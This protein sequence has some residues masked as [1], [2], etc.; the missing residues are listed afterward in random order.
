[1]SCEVSRG[2]AP[3]AYAN[4]LVNIGAISD[5]ACAWQTM[6]HRAVHGRA[7]AATYLHS[8]GGKMV[9]YAV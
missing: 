4:H 7:S 5:A 9:H 8:T 6:Q 2:C 1:M 3:I